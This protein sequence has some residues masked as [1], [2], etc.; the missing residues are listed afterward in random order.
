MTRQ[1]VPL[2]FRRFLVLIA[3][4]ALLTGGGLVALASQQPANVA[5]ALVL[6]VN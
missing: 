3:L 2:A 1:L 4:F 6:T 5:P